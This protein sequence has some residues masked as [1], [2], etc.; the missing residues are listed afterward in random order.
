M[1]YVEQPV[2]TK[3]SLLTLFPQQ[4]RL[5]V[6][7]PRDRARFT[8]CGKKKKRRRKFFVFKTKKQIL[9][10]GCSF[11]L[12]CLKQ[13]IVNHSC[14]KEEKKITWNVGHLTSHETCFLDAGLL[15]WG[16]SWPL[17]RARGACNG[18]NVFCPLP[19]SPNRPRPNSYVEI[20]T[21][22]VMVF[23]SGAKGE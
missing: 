22:T 16:V 23:G 6:L 21:F 4:L 14:F 10:S 17:I 8:H 19:L 18:L 13:L 1:G 20:L 12:L 2:T 9:Y 11:P 15:N 5:F 3:I 7:N